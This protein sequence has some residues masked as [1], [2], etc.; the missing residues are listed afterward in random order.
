LEGQA[1]YEF[2]NTVELYLYRLIGMASRPGMQKTRI[3]GFFFENKLH[4]QIEV[5]KILQ[6]SVLGYR[7]IY[8]QIKH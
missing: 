2:L 3:I 4:W 7:F 8:I 5:K 1:I 6:K